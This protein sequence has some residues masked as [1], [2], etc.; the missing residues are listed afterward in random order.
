MGPRRC[1]MQPVARFPMV[2]LLLKKGAEVDA[3]DDYG[4]TPLKLAVRSNGNL[5]MVKALLA[6]GADS[7]TRDE[8]GRTPLHHA[9]FIRNRAVCKVLLKAGANV[10]VL[11]NNGE[12][13]LHVAANR[14]NPVG[15]KFLLAAGAD[16]DARDNG[17]NTPLH[18]VFE[19][20]VRIGP[21][22]LR[23]PQ[24]G[25]SVDGI[26]QGPRQKRCESRGT[27]RRG[28]HT[29]ASCGKVHLRKKRYGLRV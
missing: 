22:Q 28:K 10:K 26:R 25:I 17:G 14:D 4:R 16:Q 27:E 9:S 5:A 13:P 6:A 12:T 11:D 29:F 2:E 1:I 15:V 24:A 23:R 7:M 21:K 19:S 3:R 20:D 8:R 18:A